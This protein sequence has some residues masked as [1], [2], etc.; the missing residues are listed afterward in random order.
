MSRKKNL[1]VLVSTLKPPPEISEDQAR[2][3][4]NEH[5]SAKEMR[6]MVPLIKTLDLVGQQLAQKLGPEN[7][8]RRDGRTWLE[9]RVQRSN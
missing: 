4:M 6:I 9:A 5:L 3:L 7:L 1:P 2:R 8:A